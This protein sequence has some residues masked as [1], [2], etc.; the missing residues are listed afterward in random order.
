ML[1]ANDLAEAV[2]SDI[3]HRPVRPSGAGIPKVA[4]A[5]VSAAAAVVLLALIV[6]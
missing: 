3:R 5:L 4:I 2:R 6:S 1:T